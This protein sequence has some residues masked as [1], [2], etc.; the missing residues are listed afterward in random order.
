M[1]IHVQFPTRGRREQFLKVL[2]MY[3]EL[4][5][6]NSRIYYQVIADND[7]TQM[8]NLKLTSAVIKYG[9]HRTKVEACNAFIDT[10]PD[11]DILVLASDDMVPLKYGWDEVIRKRMNEHYPDLS[12]VLYFYDGHQRER[13]NT[14]SVIG[15]G[16]YDRFGYVYN[17][18]YRTLYP[19]TEFTDVSRM[20]GKEAVCDDQIVEHRHFIYGLSEMDETY[21]KN[22]SITFDQYIYNRR[23]KC[24]F[25]IHT[26]LIVQPGRTGDILITLPIAKHYADLGHK[27]Y[28]YC[29][30]EY[31]DLF[32]YIDY[33][34][35]TTKMVKADNVIDLSFG[36]GGEPQRWWD[37]NKDLF[38]SFVEAKYYL[39]GIDVAK[40]QELKWNYDYKKA[41]ELFWSFNIEKDTY[42][43]IH[44]TT[45]TGKVITVDVDGPV[46]EFRPLE[47]YNVMDWYYIIQH[48]KQVIC[49]DSAL[50]NFIEGVPEFRHLN[51]T[52]HLTAREP[53]YYLRASYRNGWNIV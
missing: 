34:Q 9:N 53:K 14:F 23:K 19:D 5:A 37:A 42:T 12:G 10:A 51:K 22:N 44:D 28:W 11:W 32:K 39:A 35:P 49:I 40:R 13:I 41:Y 30:K 4:A 52:I 18:V 31:H 38:F 20:L 6:D 46:I 29:P 45:H 26:T 8:K 24:N 1:K 16:W 3:Q 33:A 27:V 2:G 21:N 25:F 36:F 48:A 47:G 7:D 15:R 50:S 17:P 43:L